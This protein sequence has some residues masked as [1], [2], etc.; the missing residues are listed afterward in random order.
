MNHETAL[1]ECIV[2]QADELYE[3][4]CDLVNVRKSVELLGNGPANDFSVAWRLSRSLFFLGQETK[5]TAMSLGFHIEGIKAARSAVRKSCDRVEGQFWLGVNLAL[6]AQHESSLRGSIHVFRAKAALEKAIHID[7]AYHSAGPLRVLARL[8]QKLPRVLGG[9]LQKASK[10]YREAIA[11]APANTV[12]RIYF[13]ECLL[14]LGERDAAHKECEAVLNAPYD[15]GWSFEI[16]RDKKLAIE[17][18]R[19][20]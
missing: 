19:S 12:T 4:R 2:R 9:G 16:E 15:S 5:P 18:L 17:M 20:T 3:A 13:A 1:K 10:T 11:Q 8:Q 14:E 7:A 6:A